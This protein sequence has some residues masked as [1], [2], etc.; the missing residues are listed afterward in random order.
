MDLVVVGTSWGGLRA[1]GV[2][3]SGV[4]ASFDVPIVIAQHR[5]TSSMDGS[6]ERYLAARCPL[7]VV[8]ADDKQ[9]IVP[10]T[11]FLAP[12]DYHLLLEPGT[13]ALSTEARVQFSRPS[14]DVLFESAADAYG[15]GT[16]GVLLTGAN[17]DGA[18]G[19]A[20]I[21]AR[22]GWTIA[23][24]PSEAEVPTMP[25]AA[26]AAGAVDDVLPLADIAP[27]L[28]ELAERERSRT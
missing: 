25:A 2:L 24:D 20:A 12:S 8:E 3:L 18:A 13:I 6:L 26:I 11:V 9:A 21:R 16:V 17:A 27:A 15:P 5:G 28:V 1:L 22:G 4:P 23:Q 14:I 7:T 19:M 10:G